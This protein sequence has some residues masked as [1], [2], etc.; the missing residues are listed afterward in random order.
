M[1]IIDN[2]GT[3]FF[4]GHIKNPEADSTYGMNTYPNTFI[5]DIIYTM[6]GHGKPNPY[7]LMTKLININNNQPLMKIFFIWLEGEDSSS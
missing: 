5:N 1:I 7:G 4:Y 6:T 3:Y 2:V